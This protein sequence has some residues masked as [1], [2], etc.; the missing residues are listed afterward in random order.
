MITSGLMSSNSNEWCTPQ[1]LFDQLNT[2]FCFDLDPCSTD[3]NALCARHFTKE[4]DGLVQD[5]GGVSVLC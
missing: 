5:W 1:D 2:E 3:S 4:T